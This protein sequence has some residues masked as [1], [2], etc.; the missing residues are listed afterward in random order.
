MSFSNSHPELDN[1]PDRQLGMCLF[2]Q[3]Y[4]NADASKENNVIL[5]LLKQVQP[6]PEYH[7]RGSYCNIDS[8]ETQ[9][10]Q[11]RLV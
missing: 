3:N 10:S 7:A 8:H 5:G 1:T 4:S 11:T 6:F 2:C 9:M